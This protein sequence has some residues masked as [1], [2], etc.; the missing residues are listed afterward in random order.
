M[1]IK[2][3][4]FRLG[5]DLNKFNQNKAVKRTN[6]RDEYRVAADEIAIGL[7]G[8]FAPIKNH[9]GFLKSVAKAAQNST[10]KI[11]VFLIGDGELR[12]EIESLSK[13]VE[14]ENTNL[15]IVLTSWIKDVDRILPGLDLVVLSSFNEGTPVSLI[16]AQAAGI[17]VLS[18][19]VR[20]VRDV[21]VDGKTGIISTLFEEKKFPYALL[22][23]IENEEKR[24]FLSQ[25]GWN[26]V[27][28]KFHYE[29]LCSDMEK[30]YRELLN[31]IDKNEED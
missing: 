27:H 10:K 28:E 6:F 25:N 30:L 5:F 24:R 18:T 2:Y 31:K 22:E 14:Q 21:V 9:A 8:R 11:V 13:Q 20:G 4:L 19:N 29:R 23:L 7:I 3:E 1:Q 26:H 15:R 12:P 17:P 16:E